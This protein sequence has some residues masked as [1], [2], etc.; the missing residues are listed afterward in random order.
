[1]QYASRGWRLVPESGLLVASAYPDTVVQIYQV[2]N[3]SYSRLYS[4]LLASSSSSSSDHAISQLAFDTTDITGLY[5]NSTRPIN[6]FAHVTC[7]RV[8]SPQTN[9]C[10]YLVEAIPAVSELGLVHVVP[11]LVRSSPA[12]GYVVR[13]VAAY[14]DTNIT[15]RSYSPVIPATGF[16]V[17]SAGQFQQLDVAANLQP[18]L[19]VC[20]KPCLV[21]QYNKGMDDN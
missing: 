21:M 4:I 7:A 11:P 8:T 3:N 9:F 5:V 6:V 10:G 2:T 17:R 13:V 1:M 20:S 16:S 18:L 15:W 19:V 12:A 14:A